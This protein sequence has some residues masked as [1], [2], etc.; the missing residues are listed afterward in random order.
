MIRRRHITIYIEGGHIAPYH[1]V[2]IV[3]HTGLNAKPSMLYNLHVVMLALLV[4][5]QKAY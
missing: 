2:H 4:L 3:F 1:I 5:L